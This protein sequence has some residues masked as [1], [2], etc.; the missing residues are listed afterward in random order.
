M[1]CK[2]YL[3]LRV[4][5]ITRRIPDQ[6]G[7]LTMSGEAFDVESPEVKKA[8]IAAPYRGQKIEKR[9]PKSATQRLRAIPPD[10]GVSWRRA[11]RT[12]VCSGCGSREHGDVQ[13]SRSVHAPD[14]WYCG[15][16]CMYSR[17]PR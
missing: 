13:G 12:R 2:C 6:K 4:G 15:F 10:N 8:P 11:P 3:L 5:S 16:S 14:D 1:V 17:L 7:L 9:D